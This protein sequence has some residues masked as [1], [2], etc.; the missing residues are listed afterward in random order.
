MA[1]K[2]SVK[3]REQGR[4]LSLGGRPSPDGKTWVIPDEIRDINAF[5]SWLPQ[6]EGFIVQRPHFVVRGKCSCW[7]CGQETPAVALGAKC[8]QQLWFPTAD[9]LQWERTE[10]EP[11]LFTEIDYLDETISRSLQEHYGF[12]KQT[13]SKKLRKKEW[14]NCCVHCQALQEEDDDWRYDFRNPFSPVS[15]EEAMEMRIIYFKL[16]FD[17]YIRGGYQYDGLFAEMVR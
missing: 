16:S 14:G 3:K 4:V 10:G 5:A 1:I 9:T 2:L 7:K 11:I 17:Y 8:Y 6:R 12:Y 13:Y 15:V